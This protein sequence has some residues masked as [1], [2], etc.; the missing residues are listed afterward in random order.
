MHTSRELKEYQ[1]IING[2]PS[3]VSSGKMMDSI[4]PATGKPWSKIPL[5]KV[6]DVERVTASARGAFAAWSSLPARDRGII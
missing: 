4:D 1:N 3:P 5:S 6:E 2:K